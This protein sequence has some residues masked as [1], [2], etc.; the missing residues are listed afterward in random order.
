MENPGKIQVGVIF[1]GRSGEHEVSLLSAQSVMDALDRAKYDV[2]PVGITRD[3]RWL[4][5]EVMAALAEGHTAVQTAALLPDPQASGLMELREDGVQAAGVT[6]VTHLDVLIPV[7]H[8]TY[9]EDGTVQ[10]LLE[11]ADLPY[12]GAGVVGSAVGMDKAIFKHV[13]AANGLPVLPWKLITRQE[14]QARGTAVLDE[15]EAILSY[16]MFTKPANLGSSVGISKCQNRAE[17]EAGLREAAQYDR[18][19]VVEQGIHVRELEVAVLGNENPAASVV[20][21]IRPRRDFYDYTAKYLAAPDSDDYS[22]LIIPA[23]LDAATAVAVQ[24][25]A[26]RAYQA[27]DCAGMGR[28]D[29]LLDTDTGALYINEINTIPGFTRISMYP[30]LWEA[31]GLPYP[32]LL[33][34]L[35]ELALERHTEKANTKTSFSAGVDS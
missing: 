27:I 12:V 5:G 3:G 19:I 4:T 15:L 35:I 33:D 17:L 10:G 22:E 25:L 24:A 20:G 34:R 9:G 28:V 8:G 18:R 14:W 30:K 29:L 6:A 16:P 13:M 23:Q 31:S 32:R 26:L 21:E 2:V 7:L 11:L 1:G